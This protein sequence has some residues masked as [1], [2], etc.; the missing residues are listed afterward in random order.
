MGEEAC[1]DLC[2]LGHAELRGGWPVADLF[3]GK[4]D[5]PFDALEHLDL[6]GCEQHGEVRALW[7]W[8]ASVKVRAHEFDDGLM[9]FTDVAL[10]LVER[11]EKV[12]DGSMVGK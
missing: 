6:E 3:A 4:L 10:E 8:V 7:E 5:P 1:E 12:L 2:P 9:V 11:S